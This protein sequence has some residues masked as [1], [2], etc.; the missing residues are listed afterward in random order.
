[1][2]ALEKHRGEVKAGTKKEGPIDMNMATCVN[3]KEASEREATGK[4]WICEMAYVGLPPLVAQQFDPLNGKIK[5]GSETRCPEGAGVH[6][7]EDA[8][9]RRKRTNTKKKERKNK[10]EEERKH[11]PI[12]WR[13]HPMVYV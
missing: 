9:V 12:L 5:S 6:C 4:K 13:N 3:A 11:G 1:M 7:Q 2:A 10:R 8:K